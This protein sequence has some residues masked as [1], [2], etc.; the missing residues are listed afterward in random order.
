M[1]SSAFQYGGKKKAFFG[2]L[3]FDDAYCLCLVATC[4]RPWHVQF[5]HLECTFSALQIAEKDRF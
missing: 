2:T 5:G 4:T 3:C 1:L